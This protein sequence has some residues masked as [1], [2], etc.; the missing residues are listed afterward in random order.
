MGTWGGGI[1]DQES[2]ADFYLQT[3][4]R[5]EDLSQNKQNSA[6]V[7]CRILSPEQRG[8]AEGG[9]GGSS[10]YSDHMAVWSPV[11]SCFSK[12]AG[13]GTEVLPLSSGHTI[14]LESSVQLCL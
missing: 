2:N 12:A 11:S 8:E 7:Q 14:V 6:K 10:F 3:N 1:I 4:R 13:G 9:E 5:D